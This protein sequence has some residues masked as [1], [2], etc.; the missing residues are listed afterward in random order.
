MDIWIH[1]LVLSS[2]FLVVLLVFS[3]RHIKAKRFSRLDE[4]HPEE[5]VL[6]DKSANFSG[7]S[8]KRGKQIRGKGIL[9]LY[10]TELVF[11]MWLPAKEV[12]I[13]LSAI[14]KVDTVRMHAG[15]WLIYPQLHIIYEIDSKTDG[16]AWATS[17][18][19]EWRDTLN[20]SL[21]TQK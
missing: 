18:I 13:P 12:V 20:L 19:V 16:V 7:F 1:I 4:L 3:F 11:L 6:L 5:A 15:R 8:S 2:L 9:A 10:E 21:P 14:K 17:H